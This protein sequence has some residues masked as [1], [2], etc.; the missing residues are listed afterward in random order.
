MRASVSAALLHRAHGQAPADAAA[1]HLVGG[2]ELLP[3]QEE[4]VV[5]VV[6]C[7]GVLAAHC[8][9]WPP[10]PCAWPAA[11]A[12]L[13]WTPR[14]AAD[15]ARQK[16]HVCSSG[17]SW[18]PVGQCFKSSCFCC[19]WRTAAKAEPAWQ[20]GRQAGAPCRSRSRP[21]W[22]GAQPASGRGC[23]CRSGCAG[24]CPWPCQAAS[25]SPAAAAAACLPGTF[26]HSV[27]F[28]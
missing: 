16:H 2:G 28:W 7:T 10:A 17:T 19:S 5:H 13:T 1:P 21:G 3:V 20:A 4:Q 15:K 8:A 9:C 11:Q 24:S 22:M 27:P 26:R 6:H 18:Q 14:L 12:R 25:P 23:A